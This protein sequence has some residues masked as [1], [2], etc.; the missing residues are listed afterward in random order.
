LT[1]AR[2][3]GVAVGPL[4]AGRLAAAMADRRIGASAHHIALFESITG[5]GPARYVELVRAPLGDPG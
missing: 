2:S 3:D 5:G 4:V 1:L